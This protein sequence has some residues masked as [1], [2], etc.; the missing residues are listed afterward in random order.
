MKE[1]FPRRNHKE[2]T[3][4]ISLAWKLKKKEF[5]DIKNNQKRNAKM[6]E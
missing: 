4:L 3:S 1:R 2:I 5:R 6:L